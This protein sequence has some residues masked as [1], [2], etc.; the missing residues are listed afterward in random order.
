MAVIRR[1]RSPRLHS[2]A[3][4]RAQ[5][6]R[7]LCLALLLAT[8]VGALGSTA[9]AAAYRYK[10]SN[11]RWVYSDR[12]PPAGQSA[13]A[14]NLSRGAETPSIKVQSRPS[15]SGVALVAIN[16]CRCPVEFAVRTSDK[17]REVA[18]R[19]LV[20]P[21]SEETLLELVQPAAAGSVGFDYAFVIGDPSAVHAPDR[22][23]R[24]PFAL[25]RSFTVTQAPPDELTHTSL[26]SRNAID[27][28]MPVGTAV[29]AA[30]GGLVINVAH[31]NFRGG[32]RQENRDEANFVQILHDDGT[33]AVYAHLQLDTVR[34]RPGQ[35]VERGEYIAN[36][37]NT[38]FSSGPH[39]HFVVLRNSGLKSESLPIAFAG[40]GGRVVMPRRGESLTAY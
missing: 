40:P 32:T 35:R 6:G 13:Q 26:A 12:P 2:I 18:A 22:P 11:G 37:G 33:T 25:A 24:V 4:T 8:G 15:A 3:V 10:D 20:P 17:G 29:H 1:P 30:R 36:S 7:I 34:V 19:K 38:G 9:A 31:R 14:V 39:L 21:Q 28:A 27:I 5:T 16:G 23:Y